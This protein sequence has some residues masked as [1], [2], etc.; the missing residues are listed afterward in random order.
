MISANIDSVRERIA[1]A[2]SRAG[3]RPDDVTLIAVTKTFP[4]ERIREA[5]RAG[6]TDIGEN[7]VQELLPKREALAGEPIRWH[8]IGHLQSNKVRQVAAWVVMVHALDSR[9]LARELD[10]RAAR[11]R[12][13]HRRARGSQHN[14]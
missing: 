2:C 9:T 6:I 5:V 1:A 8:F 13:N 10:A 14:R 4:P 3:R 12:E 7:Y 11:R